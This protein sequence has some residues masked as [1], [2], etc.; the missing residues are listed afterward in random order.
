MVGFAGIAVRQ[1]PVFLQLVDRKI[2]KSR[3]PP[4]PFETLGAIQE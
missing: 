4:G 2:K 1:M 3:F